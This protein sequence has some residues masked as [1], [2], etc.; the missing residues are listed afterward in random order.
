MA[1]DRQAHATAPLHPH[2]SAWHLLQVMQRQEAD[3]ARKAAERAAEEREERATRQHYAELQQKEA[4]CQ[5]QQR[6]AERLPGPLGGLCQP[7][8]QLAGACSPCENITQSVGAA[9]KEPSSLPVRAESGSA[10]LMGSFCSAW[11]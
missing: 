5:Q 2:P 1:T 11:Q 9:V 10:A 7:V 6:E 8:L 4:A 3:R